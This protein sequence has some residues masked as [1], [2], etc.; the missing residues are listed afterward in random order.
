MCIKKFF[1]H[2]FLLNKWIRIFFIL[3]VCLLK[4]CYSVFSEER[5]L[6]DDRPRASHSTVKIL[7]IDGGGMR[8]MIPATI[9]AYFEKKLGRPLHEVFHVIGGSSIGGILSV[10]LTNP[11]LEGYH[12]TLSKTAL[13][14]ASELPDVFYREGSNMFKKRWLPIFSKYNNA[15]RGEV[16]HRYFQDQTLN[17]TL[18]PTVVTTFDYLSSR[19]KLIK[20]WDKSEI[21]YT[22]DCVLATSAAPYYFYPKLLYS[23]NADAQSKRYLLGDGGLTINDPTA[24]IIQAARELYP[25]VSKYEVVSLG[26]GF[27]KEPF[28]RG[29]IRSSGLVMGFSEEL[30]DLYFKGQSAITQDYMGKLFPGKYWRL[31]PLIS[32][33]HT[34]WDDTSFSNLHYLQQTT[35]EYLKANSRAI[36]QIIDHLNC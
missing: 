34:A 18:T 15:S 19:V 22:R 31:N 20:S 10:S 14:K 29:L 23:V 3:T 2:N 9:L 12:H 24:E 25:T 32:S 6:T 26:T 33:A 17:N 8:G 7:T 27:V 21:F 11:K 36:D 4:N 28:Y 30:V 16:A 35:E 5:A 1:L 13:F